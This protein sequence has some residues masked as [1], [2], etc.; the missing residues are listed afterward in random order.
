MFYKL[1]PILILNQKATTT[2]DIFVIEVDENKQNL[3]GQ[4][5]FLTEITSRRVED[6]KIIDFLI[7]SL[8]DTY[9]KED[10]MLLREKVESVK[11]EHILETALAKTNKAFL[12]FLHK[13]NIKFNPNSFNSLIGVIYQNEIYFSNIGKNKAFLIYQDKKEDRYKI[14]DI[15]KSAED[16]EN[17]KINSAKIFSS[18]ISGQIP[19]KGYFLF[20][21]E[22]LPEYFSNEQLIELITTL[23]PLSAAEQIKKNLEQINNNINFSGLIIKN[24]FGVSE[25]EIE[26]IEEA[27]KSATYLASLED[28][29]EAVLSSNWQTKTKKILFSLAKILKKFWILIKKH[30]PKILVLIK[31]IGLR[32][33]NFS[34]EKISSFLSSIKKITLSLFSILKKLNQK[35]LSLFK[36]DKNRSIPPVSAHFQYTRS[37]SEPWF[38]KISLKQKGL[39]GVVIVLIAL[40]FLNSFSLSKKNQEVEVKNNISETLKTIQEKQNKIEASLLYGNTIDA[41]KILTDIN[42]LILQISGEE[43]A[44]NPEVKD[45]LAKFDEQS[46]KLRNVAD[47]KEPRK[48]A[49]LTEINDQADPIFLSLSSGKVYA[50]DPKQKTIYISNPTDLKTTALKNDKFQALKNPIQQSDTLYYLNSQT[51]VAKIDTKKNEPSFLKIDLKTELDKIAASAGYNSKFYYLSQSNNQIYR[52]TLNNKGFSVP[53]DWIKEKI[54]LKNSAGLAIDGFV[55]ILKGN[56]EIVKM[57][58]GKQEDI[59]LETVEPVLQFA[60]RLDV[61]MEKDFIYIL[62]VIEKRLLVFNKTGKFITQYQSSQLQNLRDFAVDEKNKLIYFLAGKIIYEV[63]A[64]HL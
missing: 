13:E 21:N 56:G 53:Y 5:F 62:D 41:R 31:K 3:A 2:T 46:K 29:T 37:T 54:D 52:Y 38:K 51:E 34:K 44:E 24:T 60:T 9:Y 36:K 18:V 27:E 16:N 23:P 45:I 15:L 17:S 63:G 20:S 64:V 1:A 8:T 50:S 25:K 28:Q 6:L 11:V 26:K 22:A 14:I 19:E 4:I 57:L 39:I 40:F 12:E 58:S 48:I 42:E 30:A 55:Y 43:N 49:D 35:I 10:K 59:K 47:I 61:S 33:E 7:E 32:K